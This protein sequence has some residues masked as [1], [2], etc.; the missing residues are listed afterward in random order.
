MPA[1]TVDSSRITRE[2]ETGRRTRLPRSPEV[3]LPM[4]RAEVGRCPRPR[5]LLLQEWAADWELTEESSGEG[6]KSCVAVGG[7]LRVE[8]IARYVQN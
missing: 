3:S 6:E 4:P 5:L 2:L 8:L 1:F 7:N